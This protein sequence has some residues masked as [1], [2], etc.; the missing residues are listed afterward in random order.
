MISVELPLSMS[1]RW[2]L[3]SSTLSMITCGSSWGYLMPWLSLS[4]KTI[5][6]SSFFGIFIGRT[7]KW[8]Q[9]ISLP[10]AFL[11]T[12][13][14]R[15]PSILPWSSLFLLQGVCY[16]L[17]L[18]FFPGCPFVG[19]YMAPSFRCIFATSLVGLKFPP[20]LSSAYTHQYNAR[21]PGGIYSTCSCP[22]FLLEC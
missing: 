10:C 22:F 8:T 19:I 17:P 6:G 20:D 18:E 16:P 5:S 11:R 12:S 13:A 2:M 1:T 15:L 4:E 21:G 9:F 14:F 3:N 7:R